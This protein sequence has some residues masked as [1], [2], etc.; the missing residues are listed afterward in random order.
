MRLARV[1]H[2]RA[3][4]PQRC[5]SMMWDRLRDRIQEYVTNS[6]QRYR[7]WEDDTR[8]RHR[9]VQG[10]LLHNSLRGGNCVASV[11]SGCVNVAFL[12]S[13]IKYL[14]TVNFV[15]PS[16]FGG[17]L[18]EPPSNPTVEQTRHK[19]DVP[20]S[21]PEAL[22]RP[23]IWVPCCRY[24]CLLC[25][26]QQPCGLSAHHVAVLQHAPR[27]VVDAVNS[28]A[29]SRLESPTL[30]YFSSTALLLGS[31]LRRGRSRSFNI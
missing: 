27:C 16:P 17:I 1:E 20:E 4:P 31:C 30:S 24:H 9:L 15:S 2:S 25:L 18:C 19:T 13:L 29:A 5:F 21:S 26:A 8:R 23:S 3:T 28:E 11:C 14:D 22:P 12:T 6:P 10:W 7:H